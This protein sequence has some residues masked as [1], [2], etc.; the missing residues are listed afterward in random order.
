MVVTGK[1]KKKNGKIRAGGGGDT[2]GNHLQVVTMGA[3]SRHKNK[4][5]TKQNHAS[6]HDR[7]KKPEHDANS[8]WGNHQKKMADNHVEKTTG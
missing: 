1:K 5:Q 3:A 2:A 8:K 7:F 4:H 6:H